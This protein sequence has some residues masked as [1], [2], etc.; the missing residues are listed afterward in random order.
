[1]L[2]QLGTAST[3]Y[4]LAGLRCPR[5]G[6]ASTRV[7]RT[8]RLQCGQVRRRRMCMHCSR[9]FSTTERLAVRPLNR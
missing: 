8:V 4:Q 5:C 1:M 3:P 7:V 6:C 2:H 9:Q